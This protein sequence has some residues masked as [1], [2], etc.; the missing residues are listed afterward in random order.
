MLREDEALLQACIDQAWK[1]ARDE[2]EDTVEAISDDL[3]PQVSQWEVVPSPE[4][5]SFKN[6]LAAAID[7]LRPHLT[8]AVEQISHETGLKKVSISIG[9]RIEPVLYVTIEDE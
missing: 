9:F 5:A 4:P 8:K 6:Q 3:I 1:A 2:R 7:T